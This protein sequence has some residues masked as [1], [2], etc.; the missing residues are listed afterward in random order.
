MRYLLVIFLVVTVFCRCNS[1]KELTEQRTIELEEVY[2]QRVIP[3]TEEET[4]HYRIGF[5]LPA[6]NSITSI[7]SAYYNGKMLTVF[8]A[9]NN[10]YQMKISNN[11]KE[12]PFKVY[13][14]FSGKKYVHTILNITDREAD[15]RP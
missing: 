14:T 12:V 4:P 5:M 11:K 13:Y 10:N 15:Y 6:K 7:D 2:I 9:A 1:K 3:G 8:P